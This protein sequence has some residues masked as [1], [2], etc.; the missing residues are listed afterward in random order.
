L[1]A[2]ASYFESELCRHV[3]DFA[4][5]ISSESILLTSLIRRK[6]IDR[7]YHSWFKWDVNNANAFFS[8]FGEEFT[9]FMKTKSKTEAWLLPSIRDFMDLGRSR[10]LLV[11]GNFAAFTL[12][13]TTDDVFT[14]YKSALLFVEAIPLFLRECSSTERKMAK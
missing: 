11:H 12:E 7:Q 4:A 13:K 8:L 14:S 1:L 9:D 3:S 2:A 6:A 10:N 5:E